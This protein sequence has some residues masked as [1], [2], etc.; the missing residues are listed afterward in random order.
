MA[1]V[2]DIVNISEGRWKGTVVL[3]LAAG[4]R[5]G[6]EHATLKAGATLQDVPEERLTEQVLN[7]M[8]SRRNRPPV[9]RFVEVDVEARKAEEEQRLALLKA[10]AEKKAKLREA[11]KADEA[12][13]A[14]PSKKKKSKK[15]DDLTDE[16]KAALEAG[17][18]L[19]KKEEDK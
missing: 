6:V 14:K 11:V 2:Y 8:K 7:L 4:D 1:K 5:K 17:E 10:R 18:P 16:E 15:K 12:V 3:Y 9:L 19:P 13:E